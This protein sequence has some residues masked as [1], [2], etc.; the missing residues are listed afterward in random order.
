MKIGTSTRTPFDAS[1]FSSAASSAVEAE[2]K[3]SAQTLADQ[4]FKMRQAVQASSPLRSSSRQAAQDKAVQLKQRLEMLKKMLAFASP[5]AAK[6]IALQLKGIARELASLGKSAGGGSG[7]PL[8]SETTGAAPADPANTGAAAQAG[9]AADAAV[10]TGQPAAGAQKTDGGGDVADTD[11]D[12]D[13][14]VAKKDGDGDAA[15]TEKSTG[16]ADGKALRKAIEDAKRL[17]A[18]LI[19]RARAKLRE[20]GDDEAKR[21]L[22]AAESSL[23]DLENTLS[24]GASASFYTAQGSVDTGGADLS[25]SSVA[26]GAS[27]DI[28]V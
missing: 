7:A 24:Q 9:A 16:E 6:A 2:K 15:K 25:P 14:G 11:T 12:S 28:S 13:D 20:E 8:T 5:G 26:A 1:A 23:S 19:L 3:A 4:L 17:L 27:V 18:Q 21:A 22:A 10:P